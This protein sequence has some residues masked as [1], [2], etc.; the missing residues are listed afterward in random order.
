MK[1]IVTLATITALALAMSGS[2][3]PQPSNGTADVSAQQ[4]GTPLYTTEQLHK[5]AEKHLRTPHLTDQTYFVVCKLGGLQSISTPSEDI[6]YVRVYNTDIGYASYYGFYNVNGEY[7]FAPEWES[8]GEEPRFDSGAAIAKTGRR[9]SAGNTPLYILYGDGTVRE[10]PIS[11]TETT[12]F[13]DGVAKVSYKEGR[14]MGV[15][16]INT[17]GEKIWPSLAMNYSFETKMDMSIKNGARYLRDGRRAYYDNIK[18]CWG[19]LDDKGNVALPPRYVEVRDFHNGYALVIAKGEGQDYAVFID[20]SGKEIVRPPVNAPT[21]FYAQEI[22]DIEDGTF[23]NYSDYTFYD[24]QAQPLRTYSEATRFFGGYAFVKEKGDEYFTSVNDNFLPQRVMALG[25][26]KRSLLQTME[27]SE[28]G[29]V[30]VDDEKVFTA[31]GRLLLTAGS[32]YPRNGKIGRFSQNGF[33][34]FEATINWG[35]EHHYVGI[36]DLAGNIVVAFSGDASAGSGPGDLP[37]GGNDTIRIPRI[38]DPEPELPEDPV[39]SLRTIPVIPRGPQQIND[40][41]YQ[42]TV[43]AKPAEAATVTGSGRYH[44]GDKLKIGGTINDGW[45]LS[46]VENGSPFTLSGKGSEYVV[47]GNG[48][49]TLLFVKEEDVTSMGSGAFEGTLTDMALNDQMV[50]T[51]EMKLYLEMSPDNSYKSPYGTNTAGVL[52]VINNPEE[53]LAGQLR[54]NGKPKEGSLVTFNF[55]PVPMKVNGITRTDDGRQWLVFDGGCNIVANMTVISTGAKSNDTNAI[56]A[57]MFNLMLM[58]DNFDMAQISPAH[59]RAEM[60]DVDPATGEFTFGELQRFSPHGWVPGGDP[61]IVTRENGFFVI[62]VDPG[63]S[64]DYFKG[65]RMKPVSGGKQL[66]WTPPASIYSNPTQA[67]TVARNLGEQY[68]D[69]ANQYDLLKK[70]N[71]RSVNETLDALFKIR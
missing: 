51:P 18:R 42:V 37:P 19:F 50:A 1:R 16:Y 54:A 8:P 2:S 28:A 65:V 59:Y 22:S 49:M 68:R 33:A 11:I 17:R 56:E 66:L 14:N 64:A 55:F 67:E 21:L 36:T 69:F 61:S 45:I 10:L 27:Y 43:K 60:L 32:A 62:K 40:V 3:A 7:L 53:T 13:Y 24:L 58:F 12:Q 20:T 70:I 35:G 52:S 39:D 15:Y 44:Y 46:G 25:Y 48:E 38:D 41:T 4:S 31:S 63:L 6:F 34:P 29:V 47:K 30:T 57:L 9:N 5:M 23:L 71:L 26:T